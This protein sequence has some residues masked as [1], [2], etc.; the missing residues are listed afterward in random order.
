M[1]FKK[2]FKILSFLGML[3]F[4]MLIL[5]GCG[6]EP[7]P[8]ATASQTATVSPTPSLTSSAT[9]VPS[10][11]PTLTRTPT[12]SVTPTPTI[13]LTPTITPTPTFDYPDVTVLMQANCRYGPG[14]AYLY[15]HGLFEG[16]HAEVNGRNPSGSWVWIQ[17]ENLDRHCWVAASV[18]DIEGDIRTVAVV[19]SRLPYSTF[20]GPPGNVQASRE[21]DIVSV[22]WDAVWMTE[23]DYRGYLIEAII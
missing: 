19:Q 6:N 16:D 2:R 13:S 1:I 22:T 11:T 4:S 10:W 5:V 8:M 20:Y 21:G 18:V 9:P 14:T 12:P 15:S 23:D 7:T 17:P 3:I